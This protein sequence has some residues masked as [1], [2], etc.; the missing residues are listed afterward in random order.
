MIVHPDL[1]FSNGPQLC[2]AG[3]LTADFA[4]VCPLLIHN[5]KAAA[6]GL[7]TYFSGQRVAHTVQYDDD[8]FRML[9]D[10]PRQIAPLTATEV[11]NGSTTPRVPLLEYSNRV[12]SDDENVASP[13]SALWVG[14]GGCAEFPV[15][16][17]G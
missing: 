10:R 14:S 7:D 12:A 4:D 6:P 2:E 17:N 5:R 13:L 8:C 11:L 15:V 1:P 9:R 16:V 3:R